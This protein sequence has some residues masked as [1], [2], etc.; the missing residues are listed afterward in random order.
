MLKW[1]L[2]FAEGFFI[3][4]KSDEI[5]IEKGSRFQNLNALVS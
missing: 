3:Q 2:F 1:L 5:L 4:S